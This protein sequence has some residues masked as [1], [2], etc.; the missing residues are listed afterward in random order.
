MRNI[1]LG[2]RL[3]I[4]L[5]ILFIRGIRRSELLPLKV[6]QVQT[7]F[8]DLSIAIDRIKLGK[9]SHKAYLTKEGIK[10]IQARKKILKF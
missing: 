3:R 6:Y 10:I 5:A 9:S 8:V 7:L 1:Y 2:V 4:A